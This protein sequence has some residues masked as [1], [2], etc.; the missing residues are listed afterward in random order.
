VEFVAGSTHRPYQTQLQ[1]DG[2]AEIR[3]EPAYTGYKRWYGRMLLGN[4]RNNAFH[5]AFDLQADNRFLLYFD[6]NNN[7]DLTDDG[8]PLINRGSG[9]GGPGGFATDLKIPWRY[10]VDDA[11]YDGDFTIW[12]FS[13]EAGWNAGQ[14]VSHYSRTQLE[15]R[16]NIGGMEY[17]A[18]LVDGGYND[19]DLSN[20]GILLDLDRNG[21]YDNN[22]RAASAHTVAGQ[23]L[24]FQ[25]LW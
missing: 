21:K 8:K 16:L 19:A 4:R 3:K 20:D 25:V 6:T 18:L 12:L 23:Q 13:N 5:Y 1:Q 11:P 14:Y 9:D 7:K 2:Y 24:T 15:G 17:Q 10:L 22:E